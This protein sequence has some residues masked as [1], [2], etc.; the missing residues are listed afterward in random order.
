MVGKFEKERQSLALHK[1][2]YISNCSVSE[3]ECVKGDGARKS[4]P[5]FALFDPPNIKVFRLTSDS[6]NRHHWAD[7]T[8]LNHATFK[9]TP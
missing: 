2:F 9:V 5:N 3:S 8:I 7:P 1:L 6:L 4:R